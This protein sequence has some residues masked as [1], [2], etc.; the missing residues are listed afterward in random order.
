VY[1]DAVASDNLGVAK[2]SYL[3]MGGPDKSTLVSASV[4]TYIGWIGSW[5]T[6]TVPNGS[7]KLTSVATD[8][9]GF[10]T[11]SAPITVGVNNA[12]PTTYVGIPSNGATESGFEWLDAGASVGVTSVNFELSGGSLTDQVISGSSDTAFGWIG[13]WNTATVADGTYTLRSVACYAGGVCGTSA[14]VTMTVSNQAKSSGVVAVPAVS[15]AS[16][17]K[18][19]GGHGGNTSPVEPRHR[20]SS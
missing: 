19:E 9:E 13:G 3:L 6:T 7:Y 18:P 12:P 10:R 17:G 14:P 11:R 15:Q 8:D 5:N 2:V 20:P 16:R 1:L 4:P